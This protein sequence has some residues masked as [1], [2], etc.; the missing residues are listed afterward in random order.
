MISLS[1][2][3]EYVPAHKDLGRQSCQFSGLQS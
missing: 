1:H 3:D 2:R